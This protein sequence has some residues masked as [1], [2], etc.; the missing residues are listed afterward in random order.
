[1]CWTQGRAAA[2]AH[3]GLG[4]A[5]EFA[6]HLFFCEA[7][8]EELPPPTLTALRLGA[9]THFAALLNLIRRVLP[10]G[11]GGG[12]EQE[13]AGVGSVSRLGSPPSTPAP[14]HSA[15]MRTTVLTTAED[16]MLQ[17]SWLLDPYQGV[18]VKVLESPMGAP[19]FPLR[20]ATLELLAAAFVVP[21]CPYLAHKK[22][23]DF[24]IRF[25]FLA[26]VKLYVASGAALVPGGG[27]STAREDRP[28]SSRSGGGGAGSTGRQGTERTTARETARELSVADR[29]EC[30]L[31]LQILLVFAARKNA[32]I[33]RRFHQ[34]RIMDF[35]IREIDLEFE[36][37]PFLS[38]P[39][40]PVS[41][42]QQHAHD[43]DDMPSQTSAAAIDRKLHTP[44]AGA[45]PTAP[46]L[47]ATHCVA[48][49]LWSLPQSPPPISWGYL[50]PS[51]HASLYR[52][53]A[54][55]S[56]ALRC[57]G[58]GVQLHRA[59]R[60]RVSNLAWAPPLRPPPRPRRWKR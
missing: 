21:G 19:Q 31:H 33:T 39:P 36:M 50:H 45:R 41:A 3:A 5:R 22:V 47:L 26:F 49:K 4:W 34:L 48:E 54:N 18:C 28:A 25:H 43:R 7:A 37:S 10:C 29:G 53:H 51:R 56:N 46:T 44:P 8:A 12:A 2:G 35:L 11:G 52:P 16:A 58:C 27:G 59:L 32:L 17:L 57:G 60:R 24:Y 1:M 15:A 23:V 14:T 20:T 42:T 9:L 55:T 40:R 38:A 30:R 13:V 6:Q